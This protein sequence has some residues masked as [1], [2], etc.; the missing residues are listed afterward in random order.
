VVAA[1]LE[2]DLRQQRLPDIAALRALI[3]PS[4]DSVPAIAVHLPELSS[5]NQLLN[6]TLITEGAVA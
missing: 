6:N 5:Y 1:Q 3:A 4:P 2:E